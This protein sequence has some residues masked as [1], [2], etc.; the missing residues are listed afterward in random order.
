MFTVNFDEQTQREIDQLANGIIYIE[1]IEAVLERFYHDAGYIVINAIHDVLGHSSLYKLHEEYAR[2][3][4]ENP[5]KF[6]PPGKDPDQPLILTGTLYHSLHASV[7]AGG[8]Y[9]TVSSIPVMGGMARGF[10]FRNDMH[11]AETIKKSKDRRPYVRRQKMTNAA[12]VAE[13]AGKWE[14]KTHF[15]EIGLAKAEPEL[16]ARLQELMYGAYLGVLGGGFGG[17]VSGGSLNEFSASSKFGYGKYRGGLYNELGEVN[18]E[19]VERIGATYESGIYSGGT[20][21]SGM[22][23]SLQ[24]EEFYGN[25][26]DSSGVRLAPYVPGAP[27]GASDI[28]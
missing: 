4:E 2:R 16:V 3:K 14:E 21:L 28:E 18:V 20:S 7:D 24:I 12:N 5:F 11:K 10:Q 9:I 1:H 13:Y 22:S 27:T 25:P 23:Q 26:L 6:T 17:G 19:G 15:M 8:A